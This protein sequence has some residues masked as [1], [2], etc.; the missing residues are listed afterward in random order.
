[1]QQT[2]AGVERDADF[3][4]PMT[5]ATS[6]DEAGRRR[7]SSTLLQSVMRNPR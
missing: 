2:G 4:S 6:V 5:K 3:G 7:P 1:M